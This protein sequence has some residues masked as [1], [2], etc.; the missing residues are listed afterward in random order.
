MACSTRRRAESLTRRVPFSTCDTVVKD[1]PARAAT[2][3]MVLNEGSPGG[4]PWAPRSLS[5]GGLG[6]V[7]DDLDLAGDDVGLRLVDLLLH[8]GADQ[9][10]VVAVERVVDA[11]LLQPQRHQSR[12]GVLGRLV[13]GDGAPLH[14]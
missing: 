12:L 2:C 7:V 5:A 11:V 6:H 4:G 1:T 8:L 10:F 13:N 9:L 3:L 14:P